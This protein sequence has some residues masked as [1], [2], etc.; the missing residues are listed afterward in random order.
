MR[1]LP[2]VALDTSYAV[3]RI[4]PAGKGKRR[5]EHI[6]EAGIFYFRPALI[7]GYGHDG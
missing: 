2:N 1:A 5:I 3:I 4:R 6:Y 7:L